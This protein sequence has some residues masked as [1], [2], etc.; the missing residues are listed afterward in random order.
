MCLS[1]A[2]GLSPLYLECCVAAIDSYNLLHYRWSIPFAAPP[3][4]AS[5]TT[6]PS[7]SFYMKVAKI[8]RNGEIEG[9]SLDCD[10]LLCL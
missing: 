8:E 5:E 2:S 10:I 4:C 9:Y 6:F 1:D 3:F 7:A